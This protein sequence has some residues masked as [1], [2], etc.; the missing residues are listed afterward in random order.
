M[1]RTA[2]THAERRAL[3]ERLLLADP[4]RSNR[5]VAKGVRCSHPTVA[6][7]RAELVQAGKLPPATT[8]LPAAGGNGKAL[9]VQSHGGALAPPAGAGNTRAVKAGQHSENIVGPRREAHLIG[10]RDTYPNESAVELAMLASRLAKWDVLTEYLDRS[11]L[12]ERRGGALRQAA[13]EHGKLEV[14]I[15][16]TLARFGERARQRER[17]A[18]SMVEAMARQAT[19][20]RA[21]WANG[22]G[23]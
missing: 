16:R 14:A 4:E 3:A 6:K 5:S 11:G 20:A 8:G 2:D 10:L 17:P 23:S 1:R 19:E 15:E 12:M 9:I 7:V 21:A 13:V 22:G 18:E